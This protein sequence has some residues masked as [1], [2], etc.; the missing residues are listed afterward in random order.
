MKESHA[1]LEY[2][3]DEETM[4]SADE[5]LRELLGI[6]SLDVKDDSSCGDDGELPSKESVEAL[7]DISD[8]F[9]QQIV[10]TYDLKEQYKITSVC[11]FP[12][13]LS[14]PAFIMRK[15]TEELVWSSD[16]RVM[17]K[18]YETIQVLTNDKSSGESI[19]EERRK[20]TRLENF[21][22]SQKDW[23]IL[24]NNYLRRC[25][26][27]ALGMPQV[28]YKEK[29]NLKPPG[30]SGFAPHLD[31]PSL[32]IALGDNGPKDFVTVMVA[33]DNMTSSN[34]CLRLAK[35][36]WSEENAC[37]V[38][39]PEENGSPDASGRAG[40]IPL[41]IAETLNFEDLECPGGT[42][43]IFNGWLPH[44][45]SANSSPFPRRAVFLTYN[46]ASDG[47][48]HAAYYER[49]RKLRSEWR[50]RVGLSQN[51]DSDEKAELDAL[52]T[53]PRI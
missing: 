52:S 8:D 33:I 11:V 28:L 44:R 18:T 25:V 7:G 47:M 15:L 48:F 26:S 13:E 32:R 17:D 39:L 30:G 49:M 12:P 38:I 2:I 42:I 22:D 16:S 41:E 14:I 4:A 3:S 34:G 10:D 46:A 27:A 19:I 36:E 45:S 21:V 31:N 43:A 9:I 40:A 20:L 51:C 37:A 50:Q 29:L 24:C 1:L 23:D 6:T 35:G 5:A 53:I